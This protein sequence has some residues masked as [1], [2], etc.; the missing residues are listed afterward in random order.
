MNNVS[1]LNTSPPCPLVHMRCTRD[2]SSRMRRPVGLAGRRAAST[3]ASSFEVRGIGLHSGETSCVRVHP[4]EDG[5]IV[6]RRVDIKDAVPI[7]ASVSSVVSTTLSTTLGDGASTSVATVEHLMAALCGTGVRSCV[8][9]VDGP[10]LPLL[11]GS[12]AEWVEAIY[13]AGLK[14]HDNGTR[15]EAIRLHRPVSVQDG[16]SWAIALPASTP[17]LTVGIDFDGHAAIGRQWASWEAPSSSVGSSSASDSFAAA[18]APARTFA[19]AEHIDAMRAQGLI[20]GGSLENAIVCDAMRGWLN[21]SG[22]RYDNEPARHKLLDL[23]GDLALLPGHALPRCHVVAFKAGHALHVALGRAM[24]TAMDADAEAS[25]AGS[26]E[27]NPE[28]R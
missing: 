15:F 17:K 1:I 4:A 19:L 13:A 11:D 23:M 14:P 24:Q 3:L 12:A 8:V 20:R 28:H 25:D 16:D 21:P 9:D 26:G 2:I 7:T 27:R 10:E 22:V 6:F 5:R 18:V